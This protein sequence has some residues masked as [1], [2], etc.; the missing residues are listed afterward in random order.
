[1]LSKLLLSSAFLFFT[2]FSSA[3]TD[4]GK[5]IYT[6]L[7]KLSNKMYV[8][9]G[10]GG[11]IGLSVG[12]DGIFMVDSQYEDSMEG[13]LEE[14]KKFDKPVEFLVNTH[15][16]Q[17]HTG[18]NAAI[19]NMGAI[20]VS[21][22]NTRNGLQTLRGKEG[23]K[24]PRE[25]LPTI[26]FSEEM[27][28]HFNNE[29]IQ[30]TY[31]PNA[32]TD[33]D[34]V[35]YFADSN[36]IHTGDLLFNGKYPYIDLENGGN[37][38]SRIAGLERLKSLIDQNTKIIPGHGPMATYKDL[39]ESINLL[40]ITYRQVMQLAAL[41]KTE[42]E[43]AKMRDITEKYDAQGY[44]TGYV[45]NEDFLRTLYKDAVSGQPNKQSR[46]EKNEEAREKYD[47]IKK[48]HD[49]KNKKKG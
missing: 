5:P 44:G 18:G 31:I 38:K 33:G 1:M 35:V 39:E 19:A 3:Q 36:I 7:I 40:S 30:L 2:V 25:I 42:D 14:I 41:G 32:H 13:F 26:T 48:E 6:K 24:Q 16:H 9:Q 49:K 37:V 45:K 15:F 10:K 43:V 11:N 29:N 22:E 8:Y 12:D 20:I 23:K 17:D 21:Q 27:T 34:A 28:F 4:S 47:Q 46:I